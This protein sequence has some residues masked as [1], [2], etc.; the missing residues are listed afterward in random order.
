MSTPIAPEMCSFSALQGKVS[1]TLLML[2]Q[3]VA[4]ASQISFFLFLIH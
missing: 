1:L 2:Y 4:H 3:A